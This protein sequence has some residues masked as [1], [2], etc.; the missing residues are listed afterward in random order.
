LVNI[1]CKLSFSTLNINNQNETESQLAQITK[2]FL[3]N[4]I[5]I[6]PGS[7]LTVKRNNLSYGVFQRSGLPGVFSSHQ[8]IILV[9][10]GRWA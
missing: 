2:L 5:E 9:A 7:K 8:E 6:K 4:E 3:D 1:P 10:W